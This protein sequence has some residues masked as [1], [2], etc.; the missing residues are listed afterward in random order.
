M[1]VGTEGSRGAENRMSQVRAQ[2]G[3]LGLTGFSRALTQAPVNQQ[4]QKT[5]YRIIK[6]GKGHQE[7]PRLLRF[8][9]PHSSVP[10]PGVAVLPKQLLQL[11]FPCSALK[12]LPQ[13]KH[14]GSALASVMFWDPREQK[15][16]E[17]WQAL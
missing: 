10:K 2:E 11:H 6:V 16:P 5:P 7:L 4:S 12:K 17:E 14:R 13:R 3:L 1:A 15:A 8:S 9:V